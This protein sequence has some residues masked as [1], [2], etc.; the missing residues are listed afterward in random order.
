MSRWKTGVCITSFH[1]KLLNI[2]GS[3]L[4]QTNF[5]FNEQEKDTQEENKRKGNNGRKKHNGQTFA[6]SPSQPIML[7]AASNISPKAVKVVWL[8]CQK[9]IRQNQAKSFE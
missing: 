2:F 4:L 7:L 5:V 9:E 8:M 1:S 3:P 6:Q